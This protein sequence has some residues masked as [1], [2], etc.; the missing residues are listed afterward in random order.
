MFFPKFQATKPASRAS[1]TYVRQTAVASSSDHQTML[2]R[3]PPPDDKGRIIP[4]RRRGLPPWRWPEPRPF[5]AGKP[6]G[7]DLEQYERG[8]GEDDYGHRMKM[9]VLGLIVTI[10]LVISGIWIADTIAEMRKLQDCF[11]MGGR[12]CAPISV[13]RAPPG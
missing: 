6:P 13:P 12:N 4:F 10:L 2:D 1:V 8:E 3:P 7:R 5:G 9:N 11:L